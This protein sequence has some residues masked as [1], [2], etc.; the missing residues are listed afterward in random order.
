MARAAVNPKLLN[1]K[2]AK[3][4]MLAEDS[5]TWKDGEL[6]YLTSGTVT[7]VSSATGGDVVYGQFAETQST[8]TSSSEVQVR[9]FQTGLRLR[10]YQ[11]NNGS[12]EDTA[13][14]DIGTG[15]DAYTSSNISY[16]DTNGTTGAQFEVYAKHDGAD[17]TDPMPER[18]LYLLAECQRNAWFR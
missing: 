11:I 10:M 17:T 4:K 14:V 16:I 7:P 3:R 8:S 1:T 18:N 9:V 2:Y 13:G 6:C 12:A 15:Y 5:K